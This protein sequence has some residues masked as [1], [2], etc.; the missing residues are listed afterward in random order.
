MVSSWMLCGPRPGHWLH[1]VLSSSDVACLSGPLQ[2]EPAPHPLMGSLLCPQTSCS[3]VSIHSAALPWPC[4]H[5]GGWNALRPRGAASTVYP[6]SH[7][8]SW[9]CVCARALTAEQ[10]AWRTT[11]TAPCPTFPQRCLPMESLTKRTLPTV[12]LATV[13]WTGRK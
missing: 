5:P 3:C 6:M 1:R 12:L 7:G 8:S 2:P 4:F 13:S 11:C 10:Q 9:C